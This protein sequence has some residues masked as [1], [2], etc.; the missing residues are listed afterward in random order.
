MPF[1][2]TNSGVSN[3]YLFYGVDLIIFTE[4]GDQ[5]FS[6][7]EI[8]SGDYNERSIDIKFWSAVFSKHSFNK[9]IA[10]R[11]VGS[12]STINQLSERIVSNNVSNICVVCDSDLDDFTDTKYES[13]FII[14]TRGYSWENDVY[15]QELVRDQITTFLMTSSMPEEVSEFID[16]IYT[17]FYRNALRLLKLE[18]IFRTNG[19]RLLTECS[20]D[21][22]IEERNP[23]LKLSRVRDLVE[24]KKSQVERP[25]R[26]EAIDQGVSAPKYVYGKIVAKLA[27]CIIRHIYR[28]HVGRTVIPN[29]IIALN[30]IERY[31]RRV[32]HDDDDYYRKMILELDTAM[33]FR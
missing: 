5:S 13:P 26:T 12:K 25:A 19:I 10:F 28:N 23:K 21:Q 6:I 4:G 15:H 7:E 17:D 11:A 1:T 31:S 24:Q 20:G 14:Y 3:L 2:R 33:S 22:F 16:E 9:T 18:L 29:N 8:N 27:M 32:E 30:M